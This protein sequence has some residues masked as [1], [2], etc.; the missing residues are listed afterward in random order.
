MKIDDRMDLLEAKF[1]HLRKV[2]LEMIKIQP[3]EELTNDEYL[4]L[5]VIKLRQQNDK[6]KVEAFAQETAIRHG[7]QEI[8][9]LDRALDI[10][11]NW[12]VTHAGCKDD[13]FNTGCE[14]KYEDHT[15]GKPDA[16][17]NCWKQAIIN[18]PA[19]TLIEKPCFFRVGM[20][21]VITECDPSMCGFVGGWEHCCEGKLRVDQECD[22][23]LQGG[24][25]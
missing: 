3:K 5:E 11:S 2:M 24:G 9:R 12:L 17:Q 15:Q 13:I 19:R 22:K 18:E 23:N 21:D 6:L 14:T 10:A 1:E 20:G 7:D 16:C 4:H 8:K 25:R